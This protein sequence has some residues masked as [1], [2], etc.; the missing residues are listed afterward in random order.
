MTNELK[1]EVQRQR[2]PSTRQYVVGSGDDW[3]GIFN[4]HAKTDSSTCSVEIVWREAGEQITVRREWTVKDNTYDERLTV[5]LPSGV[6]EH[7]E[8]QAFLDERLPDDYMPFFFFDGEKIQELASANIA[9]TAEHIER[10]LNISHVNNLR[11]AL[12]DAVADW[13]REGALD[14]AAEA[15]FEKVKNELRLV[16]KEIQAALQEKQELQDELEQTEKEI[17]QLQERQENSR[18]FMSQQGE[19]DVK[20]RIN[21][22]KEKQKDIADNIGEELPYDILLLANEKLLK[23]VQDELDRM[24]TEN[25]TEDNSLVE[26][27][28]KFLPDDLFD[29]PPFPVQPSQRLSEEQKE[30]YKNKLIRRLAEYTDGKSSSADGSFFTLNMAEAAILKKCIQPYLDS[31]LLRIERKKMFEQLQ[32]VKKELRQLEYALVDIASLSEEEK[33]RYEQVKNELKKKDEDC[34]ALHSLLGKICRKEMELAGKQ[35]KLKDDIKKKERNLEFTRDVRRKIDAAKRFQNFFNEYKDRL[36]RHRR[37]E[38]EETVNRY[39]KQIMTSN[40]LI[41]HIVIE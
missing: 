14:Q 19:L 22:L 4:R 2:T 34:K 24:F 3:W 36:K 31:R 18:S 29:R 30:C 38:L 27:L 33:H 28:A 16:E 10:L 7:A 1:S 23:K 37:V 26:Q 17:A 8:A 35:S 6:I 13:R 39:F 15:E 25:I 12:K 41:Q 21:E 20:R 5:Q 32:T 9:Q 40:E 11:D